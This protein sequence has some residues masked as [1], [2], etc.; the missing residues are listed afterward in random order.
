MRPKGAAGRERLTRPARL[1]SLLRPSPLGPLPPAGAGAPCDASGAVLL[2][3][4]PADPDAAAAPTDSRCEPCF[5]ACCTEGRRPY[6]PPRGILPREPLG[7]TCAGDFPAYDEMGAEPQSVR[8]VG[9]I[10]SSSTLS[11]ESRPAAEPISGSLLARLSRRLK[12]LRLLCSSSQLACAVARNRA[13]GSGAVTREAPGE[14]A[15]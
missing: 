11:S 7:A 10:S 1:F 5:P 15:R 9:D 3:G 4:G 13:R 6:C 14:A 8:S 2:G 12:I